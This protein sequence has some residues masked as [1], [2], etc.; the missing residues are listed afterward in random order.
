MSECITE[1]CHAFSIAGSIYCNK[2]YHS[3]GDNEDNQMSVCN[4]G[5]CE[6]PTTEKS[7][8]CLDHKYPQGHP[9]VA[10][11]QAV[12]EGLK[13]SMTVEFAAKHLAP[14]DLVVLFQDEIDPARLNDPAFAEQ[15]KEL[16]SIISEGVKMHAGLCSLR[17]CTDLVFADSL[18]RGH[19]GPPD[20]PEAVDHPD[21][22]GGKDN[23]YEVIKVTDAWLTREENIGAMKFNAIKYI[24]R[25]GKKEDLLK[26]LKK[27]KWYLN[28][29]IEKL[30]EQ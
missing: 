4:V 26:D 14:H 8:Y 15:R 17:G 18:C 24:A 10:D 6:K 27:A 7:I 21:H 25:A 5:G 29:L 9:F 1:D 3:L 19:W 22:C 12:R 20:K 28:H 23:P 13:G 16:V 11:E 30:E 2:H